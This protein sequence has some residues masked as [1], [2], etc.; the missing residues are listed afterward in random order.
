MEE[1]SFTSSNIQS[2]DSRSPYG[3]PE[4]AGEAQA[5]GRLVCKNAACGHRKASCRAEPETMLNTRGPCSF[6]SPW[7]LPCQTVTPLRPVTGGERLLLAHLC[8][9]NLQAHR[10]RGVITVHLVITNKLTQ[11]NK[12]TVDHKMRYVICFKMMMLVRGT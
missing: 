12:Q 9:W 3:S 6:G 5:Q 2:R 10:L 11:H 7:I 1:A 4:Y 8:R